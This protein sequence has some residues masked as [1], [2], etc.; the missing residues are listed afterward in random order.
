MLACKRD[1]NSD[2]V[3][4]IDGWNPESPTRTNNIDDTQV[5]MC[6]HMTAYSNG[7]ISCM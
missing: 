5:G 3:Y 6:Q 1:P 7:K 2:I 4:A